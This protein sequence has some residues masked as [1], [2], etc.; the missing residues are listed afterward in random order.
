MELQPHHHPA[1][2]LLHSPEPL[3]ALFS[4]SHH[5]PTAGLGMLWGDGVPSTRPLPAQLCGHGASPRSWLSPGGRGSFARF[6]RVSQRLSAGVPTAFPS[7]SA[8][9]EPVQPVRPTA[10]GERRGGHNQGRFGNSSSKPGL[11]GMWPEQH[12][13]SVAEPGPATCTAQ[14]RSGAGKAPRHPRHQGKPSG[15]TEPDTIR[16]LPKASLSFA[17]Q[18]DQE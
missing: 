7:R 10:C 8:A 1:P 4:S 16:I 15:V 11:Q 5:L 14:G 13:C 12:S 6:G 17:L 9:A 2:W 18:P 3:K